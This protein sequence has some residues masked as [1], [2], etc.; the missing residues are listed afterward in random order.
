MVYL[1]CYLFIGLLLVMFKSPIRK[2]IDSE[3]AKI[4]IHN[5]INGEEVL[6][7]KIILLR[8]GRCQDTFRLK[9]IFMPLFSVR[10]STP[11]CWQG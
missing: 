5:A 8:I 3:I 9:R 1:G 7:V 2:L 4:E 11:V 10:H 6:V